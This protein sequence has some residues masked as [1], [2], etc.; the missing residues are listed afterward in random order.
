[1]SG[2]HPIASRSCRSMVVRRVPGSA[3]GQ[4]RFDALRATGGAGGIQHAPPLGAGRGADVDSAA[5]RGVEGVVAGD[6]PPEREPVLGGRGAARGGHAPPRRVRRRRSTPWRRNPRRCRRSRRREVPVHH[7]EV[8]AGTLAAH[9][10][11]RNSRRGSPAR[12]AMPSPRRRPQARSWWARPRLRSWSSRYVV[13]VPARSMTM[14]G[15]S[16]ASTAQRAS[17]SPHH[18]CAHWCTVGRCVGS[19]SPAVHQ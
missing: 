16:G 4:C 8:E 15:R 5:A 6:R 12:M 2:V 11:S 13:T 19:G 17:G 10:I 7:R 9:A 18:A 3:G 1:M 14:A